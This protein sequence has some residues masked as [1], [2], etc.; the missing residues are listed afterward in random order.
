[1]HCNFAVKVTATLIASGF[2]YK[3]QALHCNNDAF[4]SYMHCNFT[5]KLIGTL[6][7][8][9]RQF[10]RVRKR[11]MIELSKLRKNI[12]TVYWGSLRMASLKISVF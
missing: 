10:N 1:M 11:E 2:T 4:Y 7:V 9:L 5:T 12:L 3:L 6:V 8:N